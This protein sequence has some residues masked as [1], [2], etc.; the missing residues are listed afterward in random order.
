MAAIDREPLESAAASPNAAAFWAACARRVLDWTAARG[1]EL[2]DT[3][4]LLP[5][6]QLIGPARAA[7][8]AHA[9]WLPRV[10]TTQ[11]LA[12]ALGPPARAEAMQLGMDVP[13]DL[14]SARRLLAGEAWARE[15]WSRDPRGLEHAAAALVDT[16]HALWRAASAVPPAERPAYWGHARSL[17]GPLAG[18]GSIERRLA[19]VALEWAAL[20]AVPATDRL[21]ALRP[22]A[23][24]LL[25]AGG[26][27]RLATALLEAAPAGTPCLQLDADPAPSR[28][29]P[30]G[31]DLAPPV[32]AVCDGFEDEAQCAAAQ[33][34]AHLQRG[35]QPVALVA[36]DRVLV[37]RIRALLERS[38]ATLLDETGWT[39]STTRAAG[40]VMALQ[41]AAAEG[42]GS[43]ALFDWLKSVDAWPGWR[44]TSARV[45]ALEAACRKARLA[46]VEQVAALPLD[47]PLAAFRGQ[48][49]ALLRR[50]AQPERAEPGAWLIRL[51]E[52]LAGCGSLATLQA[53]DAGRQVL[54]ALHL[55]APPPAWPAGLQ[56]GG[57]DALDATGFATW[58]DAVFEAAIYRPA[59]R[60]ATPA[61][62]VV[63]PLAQALLRPFAAIV[64]PGADDAQFGA[65]PA[66]HPLLNDALLRE[67]GLPDA[68]SRRSAEATA[69]A[70]AVRAAPLT[71]L[72][73]RLDQRE[74][75]SD[76]PL[77]E[78]LRLE[79]QR[80]GCDLG[81]WVDPR[82]PLVPGAAPQARPA[83]A[84]AA[85]LP[86]KLSA[87][88]AE[89]LR[90]CPYRWF[91]LHLLGLDEANELDTEVE[92]RDYGIWLHDVL[93]RFHLERGAPAARAVEIERLAA[94]GRA[95]QAEHG[96][97]DDEFLAYAA[98]FDVFVPRYVDW[99][100]A[101][102][103]AGAAWRESESDREVALPGV[104]GTVLRG[105]ID[106][107]DV[108]HERAGTALELIDYKTGATQSLKEKVRLPFEDT[109]LAVYAALVAAEDRPKKAIYL[110]VDSTRELRE[111]AHPQVERSA[112]ALVQGLADD[113]RRLHA[114][115]GMAA[116]GEGQTCDHCTARGLC[117]RDHW[118]REV[119]A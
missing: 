79:L 45:A 107:I 63:T 44:D 117:R 84:A 109:Q 75:R 86:H 35:E 25:Q 40:R 24:V 9:A 15:A 112:A 49:L 97:D 119:T 51:G 98:S 46:R 48:V 76:S 36:L 53:D 74:P 100:H 104:P 47:E 10:E 67:L 43:D 110:A 29:W 99:Q 30:V 61:Q 23:W 88:A 32:L 50:Y 108:V 113:L 17:L 59:E 54:A 31:R 66:P 82:R 20:G 116:L 72:R 80:A 2:R 26:P 102:D 3:V 105:R 58:L 12:R 39:L 85:L 41:R 22:G 57:A 16:A 60:G 14:L 90:A 28:L 114:G 38:G 95:V 64:L 34:V 106:R 92:K 11:T 56:P 13:T 115:A 103:A 55:D 6:A 101:R 21:Y 83:P 62:V 27:D 91:A 33:V 52:A 4:L 71:L 42:A 78:R 19:R 7:L 118:T 111:I 77:V 96:I 93:Q 8:A 65:P 1:V 37:R 81:T 70:H 69:L 68:A 18:P 73:R 89:A 94:I 5:F 87:S